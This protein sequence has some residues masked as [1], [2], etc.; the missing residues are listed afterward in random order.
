MG[1]TIRTEGHT[2]FCGVS[3]G[4][5]RDSTPKSDKWWDDLTTELYFAGHDLSS[6]TTKLIKFLR[7]KKGF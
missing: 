6:E 3:Q 5:E 2:L 1:I 4:K 7:E